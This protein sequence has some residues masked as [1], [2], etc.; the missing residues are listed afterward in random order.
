MQS[1]TGSVTETDRTYLNT[2]YQRLK[3]EIDRIGSQTQW[4]GMNIFD[5]VS[6]P[7]TT[8][9]QVGANANQTIGVEIAEVSTWALAATSILQ[10][11]SDIDGEAPGDYSGTAVSLSGD[12]TTVVI[13]APG[14]DG[15]GPGGGHARIYR[16]DSDTS[17]WVQ[18][19]SDID[20]TTIYDSAGSSVSISHDG[21]I[22]AVG[23]PL[24]RSG[25][26][27]AGET[28]IYKYDSVASAWIQLGSDITGSLSTGKSGYQVSMSDDGSRIAVLSQNLL[29]KIY[30]YDAQALDWVQLGPEISD[31]YSSAGFGS[32]EALSLSGD[33][34][35]ISIG[36]DGKGTLD[37]GFTS[38]F[39]FDSATSRWIQLGSD[40]AGEWYSDRSGGA[41]SLSKDGS[42]VA[43]GAT[44]NGFGND[45]A[46]GHVQVYRY[47]NASS[48]WIQLGSDIDGEAAWDES[49]HAVSISDDGSVV[50]IGAYRN[51]GGGNNSGHARVYRFDEKSD[52]WIKIGPDI[53]GETAVDLS[54]DAT[55]ISADG[56]TVAVGASL[57]DGSGKA[58]S[59][60]VR[61]HKLTNLKFS[62]LTS[63]G[64]S[65]TALTLIDQAHSNLSTMR[66]TYGAAINQ[67]THAIDNLS[68]TLLNTASSESRI[69]DTDYAKESSNLAT[70]QIRN[71]GAKAMLAQTNT[72]QELTLQLIE[73][74]L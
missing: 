68:N 18:L 15:G 49:G 66:A 55:S 42:T 56:S 30:Q 12:G 33:G 73:D 72:D 47:D 69:S 25:G 3:N 38:V 34:S 31:P 52:S 65:T 59:G 23:A 61:V 27:Y 70:A 71:Q 26:T 2:E 16:Y 35:T 46:S 58:D 20:A 8:Q 57:N 5:G 51:D 22:V 24:N 29:A 45:A 43:I 37:P 11:G 40:I 32:F 13:G 39:R 60:H 53:D 4:N 41:V 17:S 50:V 1:A 64:D 6:F 21:S 9:F 54:G 10:L 7:G 44:H 28:R 14:N 74:W 48:A 36:A 67:I 63:Q 19:G 62:T